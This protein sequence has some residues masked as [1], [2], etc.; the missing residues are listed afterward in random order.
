MD[1]D[2]KDYVD[3]YDII[4]ERRLLAPDGIILAD[5][6]LALGCTVDSNVGTPHDSAVRNGA[7]LRKF[8]AHIAE[9]TLPPSL[10]SS[11]RSKILITFIAYRTTVSMF[12][13]FPCS[14]VSH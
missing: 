8:N 11:I 1:S 7:E 5:N 10:P 6:I 3:F 9:V 14:T 4:M 12:V 13:F 2:K